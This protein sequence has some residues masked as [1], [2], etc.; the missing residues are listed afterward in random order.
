MVMRPEFSQTRNS[1]QNPALE[2]EETEHI[3]KHCQQ[4]HRLLRRPKPRACVR[5]Q[6][7]IGQSINWRYKSSPGSQ[8]N[9]VENFN[10]PLQ[11]LGP[12]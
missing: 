4:E 11:S 9:L 12:R 5:S 10:G 8:I 1:Y 6:V 7:L 3:T 2:T